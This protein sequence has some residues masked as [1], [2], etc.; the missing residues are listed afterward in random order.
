MV[1]VQGTVNFYAFEE[2]ILNKDLSLVL[3]CSSANDQTA[4]Y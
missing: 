1:F 3:L 2:L 4:F